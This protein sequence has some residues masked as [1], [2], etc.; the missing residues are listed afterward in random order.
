MD[1][2]AITYMLIGATMIG[3]KLIPRLIE[4]TPEVAP[5]IFRLIRLNSNSTL[6]FQNN[7]NHENK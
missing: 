1:L 6:N 7:I 2:L 4:K 3:I 5:V